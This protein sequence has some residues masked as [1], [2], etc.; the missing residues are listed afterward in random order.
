V[1]ADTFESQP[2]RQAREPLGDG[3]LARSVVNCYDLDDAE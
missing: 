3:S 1:N 2:G